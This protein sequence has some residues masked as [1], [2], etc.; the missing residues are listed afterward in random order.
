MAYVNPCFFA[1]A[2]AIAISV[3]SILGKFRRIDLISGRYQSIDGLRGYLALFVFLHHASTS[4][5]YAATGIWRS[6]P[7]HL[8]VHLGQTS[9]LLF[10]MITSFLFY[11][12]LIDNTGQRLSWT[13]FFTGRVLRLA[14]LYAAV[15]T[16]MLCLAFVES[17]GV[18]ADSPGHLAKSVLNWYLFTVFDEPLVNG[19]FMP[20]FIAGVNWSLPYEWYFYLGMPLLALTTRVRVPWQYVVFS[21]LALVAAARNGAQFFFAVVFMCGMAAAVAV[22]REA[23]VRFCQTRL[24][25]ATVLANLGILICYFPTAYGYKQLPFLA[26]SFALIAGGTDVYGALTMRVSHI[27]GEISY[28]IY[29]LHGMLL[30]VILKY[31]IGY[32]A[33]QG[34]SPNAYW[35]VV[36]AVLVILLLFATLTYRTIE[37]PG[38]RLSRKLT[39]PFER[40]EWTDTDGTQQ[41]LGD[42]HAGTAQAT[43]A[44]SSI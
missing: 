32:S 27:L 20:R 38:L 34:M 25:S 28:S 43:N 19:I 14:P 4:Y 29:L 37:A 22:R 9:V 7:T 24:A 31:L 39:P 5:F 26:T 12:K 23:F 21:L 6:P 44:K 3:C 36:D 18:L 8:A 30:F 16:T 15:V 41:G 10:F 40:K 11:G 35:L 17:Q 42:V 13:G 1:M 33:V 2:V